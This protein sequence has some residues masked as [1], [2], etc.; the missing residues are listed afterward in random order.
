MNINTIGALLSTAVISANAL[1]DT[2]MNTYSDDID[3]YVSCHPEYNFDKSAAKLTIPNETLNFEND[4]SYKYT[5]SLGQKASRKVLKNIKKIQ[6]ISKRIAIAD[7]KNKFRR[8]VKLGKKLVNRVNRLM[9]LLGLPNSYAN[10]FNV[11]SNNSFVS[12]DDDGNNNQKITATELLQKINSLNH[13]EESQ[14]NLH[15]KEILARKDYYDH[16]LELNAFIKKL[17]VSDGFVVENT[18]DHDYKI[19]VSTQSKLTADPHQD[20]EIKIKSGETFVFDKEEDTQLVNISLANETNKTFLNPK[21]TLDGFLNMKIEDKVD[22]HFFLQKTD[23]NFWPTR[24]TEDEI[25]TSNDKQAQF[26]KDFNGSC[27][28]L[29]YLMTQEG[30]A[31]D[32]SYKVRQDLYERNNL[33]A[34]LERNP[35]LIDSAEYKTPLITHKIW[36]TSENAPKEPR[37]IYT[38]WLEQSIEHNKVSDGWTHVFWL[39]NR[40]KLPET[41]KKLENHPNIKLMFLDDL[42]TSS[43]VTGNLYKNAIQKC[44]FGKASDIIRL[45]LLKK[46]GGF[47]LD[48]DYELYQSLQVHAKAYDMIMGVEPMSA[49]LGNA[50]MGAAPDH[51]VI[52]KALEMVNRNF[53]DDC[54]GYIKA[55]GDEGFKTILETGPGMISAAFAKEAGRFGNTDIV[56]S[57]QEIYPAAL[58][59]NRGASLPMKEVVVPNGPISAH[60]FG[61]HYWNT[62]WMDPAFGSKG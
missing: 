53:S 25:N 3:T 5:Y 19:K 32:H 42:D 23:F 46:Y 1:A 51:P 27:E 62:A 50:F 17:R 44:Q 55:A 39:E 33:T 38:D 16:A 35:D 11:T 48:T 12:N 18:T 37:D 4:S 56:L 34:L 21:F 31:S 2:N 22:R 57:P 60:A 13:I 36:L 7:E 47:Y 54:P 52:D 24:F 58:E 15:K 41:V 61:A 14:K 9:K 20:K 40:E 29:E 26:K 10:D 59:E 49:Y 6:R 45:E 8:K 28:Y 43:F 30:M